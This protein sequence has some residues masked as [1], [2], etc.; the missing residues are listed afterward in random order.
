MFNLVKRLYSLNSP[1]LP[2][3]LYQT[4]YIIHNY[5]CCCLCAST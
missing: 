5:V 4:V 1:F 3:A 2:W